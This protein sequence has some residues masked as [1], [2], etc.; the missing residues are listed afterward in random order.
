MFNEPS[1]AVR[2]PLWKHIYIPSK[3]YEAVK[4]DDFIRLT[5]IRQLGPSYF[6]YPGATHTRAAHSFGVYHVALRLLDRLLQHGASEWTSK[7]GCKS[8]AA[9]ALFHDLGHFP[10]THSLKELPLVEHEALTARQL[11][12]DPIRS[13]IASWGANPEQ[14]AA[15]TDKDLPTTDTET[16]FFR[17]LLSGVL[18][19]DKLDYLNRDAFFCGVPY[20]I[21]DIDF[22]LSIMYPDKVQGICIE[23]NGMSSVENILFSKYLMYKAV[24]WHKQV[25]MA[26]AM[27][28]KTLAQALNN[29][30]IFPEELY[31]LDDEGIYYLLEKRNKKTPFEEYICAHELRNQSLYTTILEIPFNEDNVAHTS[32]ETLDNR[33]KAEQNIADILKCSCSEVIIDI[34]ERISFESD[35]PIIDLKTNFSNSP[36]VFS[37]STVKSFVSS[38]RK[39][40]VGIHKKNVSSSNKVVEKIIALYQ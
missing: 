23:S 37:Q 20:G 5:R 31:E 8:F 35:L 10:Y 3:L 38:L 13:I 11:L 22:I 34:P 26:T 36:T 28:K 21:Q 27:M 1:E 33:L 29:H 4:T 14:T 12:R 6:V 18:D 30:I 40:R 17:R 15:I 25:R 24:Y 32:L 39:I 16:L 7:E 9:A 19:P 2:D